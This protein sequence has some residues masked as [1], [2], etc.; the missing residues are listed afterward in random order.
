MAFSGL[1]VP[2]ATCLYWRRCPL[3]LYMSPR[4]GDGLRARKVPQSE[5]GRQVFVP[6]RNRVGHSW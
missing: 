5:M 3:C 6:G 4:L 1:V 2:F